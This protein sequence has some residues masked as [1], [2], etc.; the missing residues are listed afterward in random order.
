[1]QAVHFGMRIESRPRRYFAEALVRG[2]QE[3]HRVRVKT[4]W[5]GVRLLLHRS[6]VLRSPK[7]R[8]PEASVEEL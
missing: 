4:L 2:P 5:T 8:A 1:M 7:F 6:G 3:R